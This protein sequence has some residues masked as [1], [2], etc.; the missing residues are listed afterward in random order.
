MVPAH[1]LSFLGF[2]ENF[3]DL[4]MQRFQFVSYA[5]DAVNATN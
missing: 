3:I 5:S 2:E 4:Y 1:L